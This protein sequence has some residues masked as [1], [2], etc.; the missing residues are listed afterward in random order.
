[1]Q[2]NFHLKDEIFEKLQNKSRETGI[3]SDELLNEILNQGLDN[4]PNM[5]KLSDKFQNLRGICESGNEES[6]LEV[7]E[8]LR[9][10]RI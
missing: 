9:E 7:R 3:D 2:A 1:M 8:N 5:I 4:Y 10:R 6:I